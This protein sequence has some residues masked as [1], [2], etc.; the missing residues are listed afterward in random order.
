MLNQQGWVPL[1]ARKFSAMGVGKLL[2]ATEPTKY[3]SPK[4]YLEA[5]PRSIAYSTHPDY[6]FQ[7][8]PDR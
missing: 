2:R 1:K 4:Q 6:Q 8:H 3:L 7:L 5:M